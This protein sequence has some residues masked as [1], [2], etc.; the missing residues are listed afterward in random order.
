MIGRSGWWSWPS[1]LVGS[2]FVLAGAIGFAG[3]RGVFEGE[4]TKPFVYV[5]AALNFLSMAAAWVGVVGEGKVRD[6][7]RAALGSRFGPLIA[8]ALLITSS[9]LLTGFAF[10]RCFV[11]LRC[12]EPS[13]GVT[14]LVEGSSGTPDVWCRTSRWPVIPRAVGV[15]QLARRSA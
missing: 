15:G 11:T 14:L 9:A 5:I 6:W 3:Y 2:S 4:W 7:L 10:T 13:A 12:A 1:L 8:V